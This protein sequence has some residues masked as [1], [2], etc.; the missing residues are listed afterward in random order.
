MQI[1]DEHEEPKHLNRR[2]SGGA[3]TPTGG[4]LHLVVGHVHLVVGP[5][6]VHDHICILHAPYH[7][8]SYL[9]TRTPNSLP[10]PEIKEHGQERRQEAKHDELVKQ[11]HTVI[12]ILTLIPSL[13][14]GIATD[15]YRA[16]LERDA[17]L[18]HEGA[19]HI[20]S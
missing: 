11:A 10:Y 15:R 1:D 16:A 5:C 6:A 3:L 14:V 18:A 7:I 17:S 9:I 2:T 8:T 19:L 12:T 13:T 20:K 4:P